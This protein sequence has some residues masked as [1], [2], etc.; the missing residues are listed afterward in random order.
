MFFGSLAILCFLGLTTGIPDAAALTGS[1]IQW[2]LLTAGLLL[3]YNLTFYSGL[4]RLKVGEAAA[5]LV[6]GSVVTTA[7]SLWDGALPAN[8]ELFGAAA[9]TLG[10]IAICL[11][12]AR[13]AFAARKPD[14]SPA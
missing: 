5:V 13:E 11:L 14:P 8:F 10:V 1:Q 4:K 3:A 7:L 6:F 9:I 2:L 12:P